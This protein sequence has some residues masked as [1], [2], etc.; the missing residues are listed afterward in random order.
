MNELL[1]N[2]KT[3]SNR[4]LTQNGATTYQSTMTKVYDLFAEGAAM[5]GASNEDCILMFKE[6]YQEIKDSL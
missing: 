3:Q 5:R 1:K 6:T 2:M 4:T